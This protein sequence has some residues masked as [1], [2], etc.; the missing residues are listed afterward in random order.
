MCGL[1]FA[2]DPQ[3]SADDLLAAGAA[4]L[5]RL[6]HRGPDDEGLEAE[7][8]WLLGHRRLSIVDLRGSHQPMWDVSRRYCLVFNG[9]IYNYLELRKELE[10]YWHFRTRGDTEVLLAGLVRWGPTYLQRAEGMWAL[11]LWDS[12]ER[13]LLMA[14][15][16]MGKKP[17]FFRWASD[18]AFACA[19][20]LP[21]LRALSCEPWREDPDATADYLRYGFAL[22]G[23]TAYLGVQELLPGHFAEWHPG[24]PPRQCPYWRLVLEPFKGSKQ[25]AA[26]ELRNRLRTA[27]SRRLVADVEVGSFLSGG[28]DSSLITSL[29]VELSSA[30]VQTFAIGFTDPSFDE[31][32]FARQVAGRLGT[33]HHEDCLDT[34][35]PET[36]ESL[37]FDVVGEPFADPSLLPTA[38]VAQLAARHLKVALS[39]DGG[40]EL[41]SGYQRY[42]A[43]AM[44][45]W[46]TRCPRAIRVMIETGVRALP[47]PLAHHSR[48]L[49]KKAHLFIEAAKREGTDKAYVAPRVLSSEQLA[50]VSP[51]LVPHGHRAP[52]LHTEMDLDS[53]QEMMAFDSLVYLPQDILRKVDRATMAH[54]L[55]ARA[56][57]LDSSLIAFSLSLPRHW[58]RHGLVGKR[59]LREAFSQYL[60]PATWQRRKQ[61]FSVPVGAWFR[62][63]LGD[64]LR[65]LAASDP[66]PLRRQGIDC[67]LKLHRS[68]RRD[69]GLVLWTLYV[70]LLWRARQVARC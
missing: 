47:E 57:F 11:A 27:V 65:H 36:L 12:S 60:E 18:T 55:E 54:S 21:A 51:E 39:G 68:N 24:R 58:H 5:A 38:R 15:D 45:R 34:L 56:P 44:L 35:A 48:S 41:F 70:Y 6:R 32:P 67:L 43:R 46:Y 63:A 23:T 2:F 40:D 17:L 19:S 7:A 30:P 69:L 16:R 33:R 59:L 14:R 49:I 1:I 4:A 37:V 13:R 8:P 3:R 20:E 29:A 26:E 42:Q 66:G 28:V 52:M 50:L 22:P 61:G 62:G 31:R 10:A 53:V 25:E 9:E 64:E